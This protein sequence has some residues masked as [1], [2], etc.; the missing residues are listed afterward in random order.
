MLPWVL[1]IT[2]FLSLFTPD[3]ARASEIEQ[4]VIWQSD[5]DGYHTYRIPAMAITLKGTVLAFCEGRKHGTGDTGDIDMLVKRSTDGGN[6]WSSQQV[7]WDDDGNTCGNPCP[8]VERETGTVW[9]MMTWN[10]GDD[11]ERHIIDQQSRDTRRVFITSSTDDGVTWS[12]PREI[13]AGVKQP[14]WTWYATGP[15]A[16]IQ[17]ERG[18]YKGRLVVPCD[19]IEADTKHYYSHIVY[20][21]DRGRTWRL[22]GSTPQHNVNECGVVELTCGRLMLNMRNY[23]VSNRCR[24]TAVSDDGGLTWKDQKFDAHLVEPICQ[25]SIRRYSWPGDERKNIILFSNPA[26]AT[27]RVNMT[28]RASFDEARTWAADKQLHIGPSAYSD[29]AVLPDG[30]IACLYEC[31][32]KRPY[33]TITL[34]SF[35]LECLEN[36]ENRVPQDIQTS[37]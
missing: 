34:A 23:D 33:E 10:R 5:T 28:V 6:A 27:D 32:D 31:G 22:G 15:G 3:L 36:A 2:L 7:I 26:S 17:I 4:T 37:E 9:L 12:T 24:Q 14:D 30:R 16:G 29:L 13:T 8:V 25:A 18:P 1:L 20:S 19:H 21:D 11:H 35:D